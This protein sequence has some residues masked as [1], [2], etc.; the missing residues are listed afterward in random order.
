MNA[1]T[2]STHMST[3]TQTMVSFSQT[4]MPM[5]WQWLNMPTYFTSRPVVLHAVDHARG[6]RPADHILGI[7]TPRQGAA[8]TNAIVLITVQSD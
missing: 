4:E 6:G 2:T 7:S 5:W 8:M 1:T 3:I